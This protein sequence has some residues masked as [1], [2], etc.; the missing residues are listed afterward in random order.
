MKQFSFHPKFHFIHFVTEN[1]SEFFFNF[2]RQVTL[3][4]AIGGADMPVVI[5]VLNSYS[6]ESPKGHHEK[7]LMREV[8]KRK[9]Q[10][11]GKVDL[12]VP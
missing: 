8:Q 1:L 6:G 11:T 7:V 10:T 2:C 3:T 5:T 9:A 12:E 4:M